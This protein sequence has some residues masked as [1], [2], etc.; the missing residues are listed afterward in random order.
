MK[1]KM[2]TLQLSPQDLLLYPSHWPQEL[3]ALVLAMSCM[4]ES[5]T[6]L[7]RWVATNL[8]AAMMVLKVV[9]ELEV[10]RVH[11]AWLA[12]GSAAMS[13]KTLALAA[14]HSRIAFVIPCSSRSSTIDVSVI[15]I[16]LV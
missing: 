1:P 10:L 6:N 2:R 16:E 12:L 4:K 11:S 3:S 13:S 15:L 7:H 14:I 8:Q 5:K 9:R